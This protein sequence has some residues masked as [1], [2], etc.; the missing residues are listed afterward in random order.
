MIIFKALILAIIIK[1]SSFGQVPVDSSLINAI[2]QVETG[3]KLGPIRGKHGEL[4][5]FQI[6]KAYWIDSK[7]KGNF[8][9]CSDYDYSVRVVEAY[10][11]KYGRDYLTKKDYEALARLHNS[12]PDWKKKTPKTDNYWLLIKKQ[13][14][15]K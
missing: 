2:H 13:I 9:Q 10:F 8:S 5:P 15:G 11:N 6:T 3:E 1:G 4:G 14:N 7:V 12:G